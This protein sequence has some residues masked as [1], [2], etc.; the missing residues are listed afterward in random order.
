M[1]DNTTKAVDLIIGQLKTA[2][3]VRKLL[4]M[5]I[6][7]AYVLYRLVSHGGYLALNLVLL[8]VTV[9]YM[10]FYV[11]NMSF[12]GRLLNRKAVEYVNR[13]YRWTRFILAAVGT[14]LT[15]SGFLAVGAEYTTV[16]LILAIVLPVFLVLQLILD[17][18]IDYLTYCFNM[19]KTAA[20]ADIDNFKVQYERPISAVKG[21]KDAITG[22]SEFKSGV[23]GIA[24]AIFGKKQKNEPK[25][26]D[27]KSA[28]LPNET[29]KSVQPVI[30]SEYSET[31]TEPVAELPIGEELAALPAPT[32]GKRNGKGIMARVFGK[33]SKE[34]QETA[35][36]CEQGTRDNPYSA[37]TAV[38]CN[39]SDSSADTNSPTSEIAAEA[40]AAEPAPKEGRKKRK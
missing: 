28:E 7:I 31:Q 38:D 30:I 2:D 34:K 12:D 24:K 13:F 11:I 26:T 1:I 19:L 3:K 29:Q 36:I 22:M 35:E 21:V 16:N 25:I 23:S 32:E 18:A 27:G 33:K 37:E 17:L 10:I 9:A 6:Y 14:G 5:L 8:A 39:P 4:T 40:V 20:T 15:V